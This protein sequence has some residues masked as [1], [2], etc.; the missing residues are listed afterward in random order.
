MSLAGSLSHLHTAREI[1]ISYKQILFSFCTL[2]L[3]V[4]SL[5]KAKQA[6]T[7]CVIQSA[8]SLCVSPQLHHPHSRGAVSSPLG[9]QGGI[10]LGSPVPNLYCTDLSYVYTPNTIVPFFITTS[11]KLFTQFSLLFECWLIASL[12]LHLLLGPL[13]PHSSFVLIS[14]AS[15]EFSAFSCPEHSQNSTT[16]FHCMF[17]IYNFAVI[18][19][20]T[21][22]SNF[23]LLEL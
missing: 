23:A 12:S 11:L 5:I 7:V 8:Y 15:E 21:P 4:L 20:I 17:Y 10:L 1:S 13:I 6:V 16:F 2:S 18:Y 9:F 3:V 22:Q 19:M 14:A